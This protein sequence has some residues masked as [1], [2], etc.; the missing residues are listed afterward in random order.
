MS[1]NVE[2]ETKTSKKLPDAKKIGKGF[3]VGIFAAGVIL[4][5]DDQVKKLYRKSK[6]V[7]TNED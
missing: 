1:E 3:A 2:N 5:I 6:P 7:E 4:L